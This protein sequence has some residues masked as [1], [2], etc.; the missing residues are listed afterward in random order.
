MYKKDRSKL[1][2][3]RK[4]QAPPTVNNYETCR[5]TV[6]R[7][8]NIQPKAVVEK[9]DVEE[10]VQVVNGKDAKHLV[11]KPKETGKQTDFPVIDKT[12]SKKTQRPRTKKI[13]STES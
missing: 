5:T 6:A 13:D 10:V 2:E 4:K 8:L 7:S 12:K 1:K 9:R 3:V 11:H